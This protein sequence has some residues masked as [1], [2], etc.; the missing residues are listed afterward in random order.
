MASDP[1]GQRRREEHQARFLEKVSRDIAEKEKEGGERE[2]EREGK[3]EKERERERERARQEAQRRRLDR[4]RASGASGCNQPGRGDRSPRI[5]RGSGEQQL[6]DRGP[7]SC[8]QQ[9]D[10]AGGTDR[11]RKE[12]RRERRWSPSLGQT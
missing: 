10:S 4:E 3:R 5:E 1:E 8:V 9:F 11:R 2:R 12:S 6:D 7:R